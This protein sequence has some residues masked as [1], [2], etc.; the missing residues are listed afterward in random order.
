[1][2]GASGADSLWIVGAGRAGLAL[3]LLLCRSGMAE[4]IGFTGHR[5]EAPDHPLF[6]GSVPGAHY[7]DRL[8][9]P[10]HALTGV[11]LAVPDAALPEVA[12]R[13]AGLGLPAKVPVL[14][15]SGAHGAEVLQPLAE[16]GYSTGT[17]HPLAA[18]ADPVEGA[19]RLRGVWWG[20]EAEGV[21]LLL[22]D[23]IVGA[24]EGRVL[25][26]APGA[27]PLYHAAAV[28]ASNYVV[29]LLGVAEQ[30]MERAGAE[31]GAA[32]AALVSLAAGAVANAEAAGPVA[33]LTGPIAR[34][35]VETLRLHL[36]KLSEPERGLYLPLAGS[37]LR[38]AERRGLDRKSVRRIETLLREER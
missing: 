29:A 36:S 13:L 30:L 22:A 31:P 26:V 3:G 15:L 35:D 18:I 28:F 23:R 33:A 24:A 5:A 9:P 32:R 38:L 20:V 21:A 19:G 7:S 11:L 16:A 8:Q 6:S 25:R 17:L 4:H 34:G 27:K 10:E 2:S 14:H 1:M 37:V 12:R